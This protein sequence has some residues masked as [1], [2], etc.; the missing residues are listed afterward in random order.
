MG[1]LSQFQLNVYSKTLKSSVDFTGKGIASYPNGDVFEGA[2]KDGVSIN[3]LLTNSINQKREC[4]SGK[5]TYFA[6]K[7]EEGVEVPVEIYTGAWTN[8]Q[9]SGIGK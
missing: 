9:K 4:E 2:F 6:K 3:Y 8:N 5:Y 7:G 1:K